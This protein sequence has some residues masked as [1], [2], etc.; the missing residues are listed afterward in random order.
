MASGESIK[1]ED[2]ELVQQQQQNEEGKE[3]EEVKGVED[4]QAVVEDTA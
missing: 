4:K 1:G 2:V 3:E